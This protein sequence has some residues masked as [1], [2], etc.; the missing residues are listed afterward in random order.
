MLDRAVELAKA[1][2]THMRKFLP[3]D[4]ALKVELPKMEYADDAVE[5]LCAIAQA[6]SEGKIS[7]SEE[8]ALVGAL[9]CAG[10]RS[11]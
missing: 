3:R 10:H 1:G 2:D 7:H 5:A 9:V 8:A 4:R 6:V 11:E